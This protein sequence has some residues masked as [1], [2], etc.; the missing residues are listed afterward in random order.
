MLTSV[1]P[2]WLKW[3][4]D[5][6]AAMKDNEMYKKYHRKHGFVYKEA[7][8]YILPVLAS[9]YPAVLQKNGRHV[10]QSQQ[11]KSMHSGVT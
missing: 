6:K 5:F 10:R 1:L 4:D 2:N 11:L 7:L 3:Q 8:P 9:N